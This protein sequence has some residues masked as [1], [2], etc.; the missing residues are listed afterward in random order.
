MAN[1]Y[2]YKNEEGFHHWNMRKVRK[3]RMYHTTLTLMLA[4]FSSYSLA[5]VT[6]FGSVNTYLWYRSYST[7]CVIDS[8]LGQRDIRNTCNN[9]S[10]LGCRYTL[11]SGFIEV[12]D[13]EKESNPLTCRTR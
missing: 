7:Y 11:C 9:F 1:Y 2:Q 10:M 3:S 8:I 5:V 6:A 4:I 12:I 13:E